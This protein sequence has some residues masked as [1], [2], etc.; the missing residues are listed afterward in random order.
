MPGTCSPRLHCTSVLVP[1][2]RGLLTLGD[3][4]E[5]A[6]PSISPEPTRKIAQ[7]I[8]IWGYPLVL[9]DETSKVSTNFE[10]PTGEQGDQPISLCKT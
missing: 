7:E 2:E 6:T 8:Y 1:A 9:M 10:V 4:S 3:N 5:I